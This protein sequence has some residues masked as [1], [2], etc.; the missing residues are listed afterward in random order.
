MMTGIAA[1]LILDLIGVLLD[2]IWLIVTGV[3]VVTIGCLISLYLI[4][5]ER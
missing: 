2:E 5:N 4:R 3:L 1:M